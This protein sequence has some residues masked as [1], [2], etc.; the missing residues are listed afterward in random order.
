MAGHIADDN[1]HAAICFLREY[2]EEISAYFAG[3]PVFALDGEARCIG[4]VLGNEVL[5]HAARGLHL[6][7]KSLF[8]AAGTSKTKNQDREQSQQEQRLRCL[9]VKNRERFVR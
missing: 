7:R 5:L 6:A 2:L 1:Q 9:I 8:L 3:R 4:E